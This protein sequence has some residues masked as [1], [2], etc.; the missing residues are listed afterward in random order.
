VVIDQDALDVGRDDPPEPI[1]DPDATLALIYTS[2][3]TGHPR[4]VVVMHA[5]MLAN[6]QHVHDWMPSDAGGVC[7]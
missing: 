1:Y 4:G 7:L 2:G 5:N 3:T 6:V